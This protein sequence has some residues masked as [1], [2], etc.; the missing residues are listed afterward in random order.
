MGCAYCVCVPVVSERMC[1]R[2]CVRC[3]CCSLET[4]L[5]LG[6]VGQP[7]T[8]FEDP[9]LSTPLPFPKIPTGGTC[10]GLCCRSPK[11]S[12]PR[13]FCDPLSCSRLP[14]ILLSHLHQRPSPS[15]HNPSNIRHDGSPA[16]QHHCA[17][18][19]IRPWPPWAPEPACFASVAPARRPLCPA[20]GCAI[21]RARIAIEILRLRIE[22]AL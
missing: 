4:G 1:V 7:G 6:W 12:V 18:S 3:C 19:L 2:S 17:P 15:T 11:V 22:N 13:S 9:P 16:A 14:Q 8:D 5:G 10:L 20:T 21:S